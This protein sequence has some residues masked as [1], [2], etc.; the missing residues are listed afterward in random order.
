MSSSQSPNIF[1]Y[2]CK[3]AKNW[4]VD[5]VIIFKHGF[6]KISSG[7]LPLGNQMEST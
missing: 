3:L 4:S 7:L 1:P 5:T 6:A 2:T